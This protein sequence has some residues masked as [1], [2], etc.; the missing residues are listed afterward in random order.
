MTCITQFV[1]KVH[2]VE[3]EIDKYK[4]PVI[5]E[6]F[7]YDLFGYSRFIDELDDEFSGDIQEYLTR[8]HA[9]PDVIEF[10]RNTEN[11]NVVEYIFE[12]CD[13]LSDD[14]GSGDDASV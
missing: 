3:V 8:Q 11:I 5:S 6:M 9:K 4:P 2:D 12:Y 14:E 7:G 1:A 13:E 10:V